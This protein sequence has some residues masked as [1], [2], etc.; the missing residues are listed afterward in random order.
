M[1]FKS[2]GYMRVHVIY[3][4]IMFVISIA[5]TATGGLALLREELLDCVRGFGPFNYKGIW[6][7]VEFYYCTV[8]KETERKSEKERKSSCSTLERSFTVLCKAIWP[9]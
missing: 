2:C 3:V 5:R 6:P 9:F 7:L 8:K 4:Q 1:T